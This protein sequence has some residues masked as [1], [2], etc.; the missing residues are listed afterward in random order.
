MDAEAARHP[1]V[2][3]RQLTAIP[4]PPR[5]LTAGGVNDF[6]GAYQLQSIVH[7][8]IVTGD[9]AW[10]V[11]GAAWTARMLAERNARGPD[12]EPAG[13]LDTSSGVQR[14][15]AWAGFTGHNFTPILHLARVIMANPSLADLAHSSTTIG[16]QVRGRME[17]FD[18]AF[19]LHAVHYMVRES[20]SASLRLP[21]DLPV[22]N[23]RAPGSEY[24]ANMGAT[25]FKAAL[26]QSCLKRMVGEAEDATL[27]RQATTG[28]VRHLMQDVIERVTANG[29][30]VLSW[31]YATYIPRREDIGH[32]NV[33]I[34]VLLTAHRNGY[35]VANGDIQ[36]VAVMADMLMDADGRVNSD[37]IDGRNDTSRL[38]R[39]I[40]DFIL[41]SRHSAGVRAKS[42]IAVARS[43]NFAYQGA[44]LF[45]TRE[46]RLREGCI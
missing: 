37:L 36:H 27:M 46:P 41:L 22:R 12:G 8:L 4:S 13:W 28:F 40:Y 7:H 9:P 2:A 45:A 42:E 16:E 25:F 14:P 32:A 24:P 29:R 44:W 3:Q 15:Y 30:P 11:R 10:A 35:P 19:A 26:N 43:N 31:D 18:R 38:P 17:Q 1:A 34:R 20:E 6:T 5:L 39:S 23:P 21:R 33:V